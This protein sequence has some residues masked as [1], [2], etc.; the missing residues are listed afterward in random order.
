MCVRYTFILQR[1]ELQLRLPRQLPL[2][3]H[4]FSDFGLERSV[5]SSQ[6]EFERNSITVVHAALGK[7]RRKN[8][9]QAVHLLH[10]C[11]QLKIEQLFIC[12]DEQPDSYVTDTNF[13][14][15]TTCLFDHDRCR[16]RLLQFCLHKLHSL[17]PKL[18]TRCPK[19]LRQLLESCASAPF[20]DVLVDA[21]NLAAD[22]EFG[23]CCNARYD[24]PSPCSLI[25][26][27]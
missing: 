14:A 5:H 17:W 6:Q 16:G 1:S 23:G 2:Q 8:Y 3:M 27:F 10:I 24:S 20:S 18:V 13:L 4:L 26:L 15:L 12:I 25:A 9:V 7:Q 21:F 22:P 11:I 19:S